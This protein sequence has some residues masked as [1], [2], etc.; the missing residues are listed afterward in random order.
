MRGL[1][2]RSQVVVVVVGAGLLGVQLVPTDSSL[3]HCFMWIQDM[4]VVMVTVRDDMK[5]FGALKKYIYIF[6]S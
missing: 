3:L 2:T 5:L 1:K 4:I 6:F